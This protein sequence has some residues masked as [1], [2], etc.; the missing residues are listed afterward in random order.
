MKITSLAAYSAASGLLLGLASEASGQMTYY[1]IDPDAT[2]F[3][4]IDYPI[5]LNLDG[6]PEMTMHGN[7]WWTFTSGDVFSSQ[8][9]SFFNYAEIATSAGP[10]QLY[11]GDTVNADLDFNGY[12]QSF[13]YGYNWD[14]ALDIDAGT[15]WINNDS[16]IGM[17]FEVDG[18]N[19]Y[20]WI[21]VRL[22]QTEVNDMP[23][24]NCKRTC[25]ECNT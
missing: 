7:R 24:I 25:L 11:A 1:N 22:H 10:L 20:G 8:Q 12:N 18:N 16:Y 23:G 6:I 15:S 3:G 19:H 17:R 4:D 21:R 5:D 14:G 13:F 2:V 9:I